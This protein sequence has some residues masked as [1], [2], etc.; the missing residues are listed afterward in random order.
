[1]DKYQITVGTFDKLAQKYQDKYM[2]MDFY[3]DTYDTFCDFVTHQSAKIFEIGCGPGNITRYLLNKRPDFNILATDLS[4]KMVAL[5]KNNNPEAECF[6]LDSREINKVNQLFDAIMCGFCLPYLS[7]GD[8]KHLI[9]NAS[10]L[11]NQDGIIYLST[12]EDTNDKSGFQTS[13]SGDQV[14]IHYHQHEFLVDTL[15]MNGFEI[16]NTQRKSFPA[17]IGNPAT[18]LFIIAKLSK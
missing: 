3:H 15:I 9:K 11:L 12:M 7:Q 5:A 14:Y 16:L 17:E 13:S 2:H 1:M 8:I 6:V 4:P 10:Q 18:D